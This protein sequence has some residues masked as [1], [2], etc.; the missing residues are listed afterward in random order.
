VI[1]SVRVIW[2]VVEEKEMQGSR[3]KTKTSL[4]NEKEGVRRAGVH[5]YKLRF[6]LLFLFRN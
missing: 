1:Q 6:I 5:T 4:R 2:H 3:G